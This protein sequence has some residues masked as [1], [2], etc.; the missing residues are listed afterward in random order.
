MT[1]Q[2]LQTLRNMGNEGE[3]AADEIDRLAAEVKLLHDAVSNAAASRIA[4][5][6]EISG[7]RKLLG[8]VRAI[9]VGPRGY[10]SLP[11]LGLFTAIDTAMKEPTR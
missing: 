11:L 5:E 10:C 7:L 4:K 8:A 2:E 6:V 3:Q 1:P 9:P